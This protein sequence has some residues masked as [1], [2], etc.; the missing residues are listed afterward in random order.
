MFKLSSEANLDGAITVEQ[1]FIVEYMPYADGDYVKVYLYG[2]SLAARK[3]DG[4]DTIERLSKRLGM[5][6][7]TVDAAIEYWTNQGLMAR[8][9]DDV[10]YLS[11]RTARPKIKKY[12]VD[13]YAEFNRNCQLFVTDRQITPREYDEYYAF[14][15]KF[16]VEWQA[17]V[18]IVRYCTKLKGGNVSAPY[19]LAVSRNL[20]EGGYRTRDDIENRLEEYGVYY[21]DLLYVLAPLGKHPDHESVALYKKWTVTMRFERE[22]IRRVAENVKKGGVAALDNKLNT[23]ASLE[24]YGIDKIEA[25]ENERKEM[26]KLAKSVNKSLG[27]F[28]E[29]VE[30]E[31]AMYVRPW[32]NLGFDA[33]AILAAADYCMQNGLK[34][35]PDLDA[36]L[37]ELLRGGVTTKAQITA[38][39]AQETRYDKR[40]TEIMQKIGLKGAVRPAYRT[41][42]SN[43]ADN[44]KMSDGWGTWPYWVTTLPSE[45]RRLFTSSC[46]R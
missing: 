28:Y 35:L 31:I 2:L 33:E 45:L 43:W 36:V 23:Y 37:R 1:K 9:G 26:L 3:G 12:D 7:A 30:P 42:Y 6:V 13:K 20:I 22:T 8:M 34:T 41:F 17:M 25:Y 27:I 29:N 19:I 14:M 39:Q 4:D 10:T 15:E 44:L 38:R 11:L 18:A 32:L 21:N 5:D 24:L 40:I 46:V 16:D